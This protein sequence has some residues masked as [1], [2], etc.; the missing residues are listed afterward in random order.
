MKFIDS[1]LPRVSVDSA[2]RPNSQSK[3]SSIGYWQASTAKKPRYI[4]NKCTQNLAN[5]A[6][7][8]PLL[9]NGQSPKN[10]ENFLSKYSQK[11]EKEYIRNYLFF[12]LNYHPLAKAPEGN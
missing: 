8:A 10:L 11:A 12:I 3:L 4:F 1:A 9:L 5:S 7:F 6:T 2:S